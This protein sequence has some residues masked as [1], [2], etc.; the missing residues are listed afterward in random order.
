L[1]LV[2]IVPRN[3]RCH[4]TG[5]EVSSMSWITSKPL[6]RNR[7]LA[8]M[9]AAVLIVCAQPALAATPGSLAFGGCV[10]EASAELCASHGFGLQGAA[11][12]AVS[13]DG[14]NVYTAAYDGDAVGVYDRAAEGA[15]TFASCISH[16]GDSQCARPNGDFHYPVAVAVSPDGKEVYALG[17]GDIEI[18][19]RAANGSL[20]DAGCVGDADST[21]TCAVSAPG[22]T[23]SPSSGE[24]AILVS[25][26]GEY[27]YTATNDFGGS[28]GAVDVFA[29]APD[30]ALATLGCIASNIGTESACSSRSGGLTDAGSLALSPTGYLY[31]G[32]LE[33]VAEFKVQSDGTLSS[34][35]CVGVQSGCTPAP[36]LGFVQTSAEAIA[37]SPDGSDLYATAYVTADSIQELTV[38]DNGTLSPAGCV[39]G[40]ATLGCAS[41]TPL[42]CGLRGLAVTPDGL[43]LY[44]IDSCSESVI[45]F[46]RAANGSLTLQGCLAE[47][48]SSFSCAA[49][50]PGLSYADAITLAPDGSDVLVTGQT[51]DS[52][53]SF[54]RTPYPAPTATI[55]APAGGAVYT[56]GAT[57]PAAYS[58]A[59]QTGGAGLV[60]CDGN[61]AAGAALPTGTL[62]ANTFTVTATDRG[63]LHAA[64]TVTY[65]VIAAP[66]IGG[67]GQ[68]HRVWRDSGKRAGHP[69]L[70]TVFSLTSNEANTVVL[71]F[72]RLSGHRRSPAG[73]VTVDAPAGLNR[74]AFSGRTST[75]RTLPAGSYEVAVTA[76]NAAG[77]TTAPVQLSFTIVAARRHRRVKGR[78]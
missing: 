32:S 77:A 67:L 42:L 47:N 3:S 20:T 26:N 76:T 51:G 16:S 41:A 44:A 30:G 73:T 58:C 1:P 71:A 49:D 70:G 48:G 75:R 19:D 39:G 68:S 72:T 60:S 53:T 57:V 69:P 45:T 78:R 22:Q 7:L 9:V 65:E 43:D 35:G 31:A 15:L 14:A 56:Q 27:V 52:V 18:F 25:P 55:T 6:V 12:I 74:V 13:P 17:S 63:G 46:A 34:I 38:S 40:K 59:D 64:Q 21:E 54:P 11:G 50:S 37:L 24:G 66:S 2:A 36:N 10:S 29:R 23:L 4:E 61:V 62:G 8:P 5:Q 28:N 33:G